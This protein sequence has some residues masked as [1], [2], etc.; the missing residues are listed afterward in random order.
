MTL[1]SLK[2]EQNV[3]PRTPFEWTRNQ[4]PCTK[5]D[6]KAY[7]TPLN[8]NQGETFKPSSTVTSVGQGPKRNNP[9]KNND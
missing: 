1:Y 3:E 5:T 8:H 2:V 9:L 4:N 7:Q 6:K